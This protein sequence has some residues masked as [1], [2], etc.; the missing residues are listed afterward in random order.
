MNT[1][2]T[3]EEIHADC[4]KICTTWIWKPDHTSRL[5]GY[6]KIVEMD[7]SFFPGATKFNSGRS[8]DSSWEDD[9]KLTFG[10]TERDSLDAY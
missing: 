2:H 8:L 7:E 10:P 5:G 3:L 9:E 6:W 4:R 1:D